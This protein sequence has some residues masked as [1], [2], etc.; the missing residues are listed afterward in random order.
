MGTIILKCNSFRIYWCRSAALIYSLISHFLPYI[1]I[2][3]LNYIFTS[4]LRNTHE[5]KFW[6]HKIPTRKKI[7]THEFAMRIKL[8][9]QNT[10]EI[11]K[12]KNFEP[13]KYLREKILNLRNTYEKKS[14]AHEIPTRKKFWTHEG[15]I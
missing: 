14:W 5:K 8:H 13:T 6:N 9:P 4:H 11:P 1:I 3:F 10:H 15:M 2:Q 12:R 7:W